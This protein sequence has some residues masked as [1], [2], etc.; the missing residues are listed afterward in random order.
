M[1]PGNPQP[2]HFLESEFSLMNI[3]GPYAIYTVAPIEDTD[4]FE[5]KCLSWGFCSAAQA[6]AAVAEV[7]EREGVPEDECIVLRWVDKE[8]A[9]ELDAI[10]AELQRRQ[11]DGK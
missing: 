7:A 5:H 3:N 2:N 9:D 1:A 8:D 11:R 4:C 6:W 10:E